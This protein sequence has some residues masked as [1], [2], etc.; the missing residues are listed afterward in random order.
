MEI[1]ANRL[2]CLY[3]ERLL[4]YEGW[5]RESQYVYQLLLKGGNALFLDG[6]SSPTFGPKVNHS[7]NPNCE[8]DHFVVDGIPI[9]GLVST[10]LIAP[11]EF[12]GIN[13]GTN[14]DFIKVCLCGEEKCT[15]KQ[16]YL[17]LVSS[18]PLPYTVFNF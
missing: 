9:F 7:C 1:P 18:A 4:A 2:V 11:R 13:Y 14:F 8:F 17:K 16:Q 3:G 10:R 5:K 12:L 15:H 6:Q